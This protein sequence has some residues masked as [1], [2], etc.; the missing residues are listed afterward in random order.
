MVYV[1]L[2]NGFEETEAIAPIDML[3]RA[4]VEVVTVGIGTPMP[5]GAHGIAVQADITE[6]AVTTDG[7]QGVV[8]P[9]GMPGTT[10]LEASETVQKLLDYA[11][12]NGLVIGAICAAPSVV[13]HKGLLDGRR[14]TCY[15]GFETAAGACGEPAVRDGH[16]VTGKGAGTALAFGAK[17][18]EALCGS[19]KA[20]AVQ[21]AMQCTEIV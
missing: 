21:S 19:E 2:A 10:N 7:L 20:A 3:L 9:G 4:G 1:L 18:I 14:Y 11:A 12:E 13:G 15:P 8:L 6:D 17:L 16:I 5:C